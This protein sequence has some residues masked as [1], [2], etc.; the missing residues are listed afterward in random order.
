[1]RE[2]PRDTK[3]SGSRWLRYLEA[4]AL[5]I[6]LIGV[7]VFFSVYPKTANT[8]PTLANL[9]VIFGNQSVLALVALAALIPLVC[10]EWDLSVGASAGLSAV[11]CAKLLSNGT[12]LGM[13]MAA[14]V[15]LGVLVGA[16]NAVL[17]TKVGTNAV[18]TTLGTAAI[19]GGVVTQVTGGTA[20]VSNIPHILT[21]FGSGNTFGVPNTAYV[22]LGVAL[23]VY[24]VLVHTPAGRYI[25]ALGSNREAAA[26]IG[27]RT[28]LILGFTFVA[29]GG[30]AGIAGVLQVARA[31]GAD[32]RIGET[33]TL[34]ALAAAFLSAAAIK[35]GQYNVGG[36]IVA[37]FLLATINSGLAI[38]GAP[39]YLAEYVNGAALIV[40]VALAVNLGRVKR[41]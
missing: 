15:S 36:T 37:L 33:L 22:L 39:P 12:P 16:S 21:R 3:R 13:A 26:L 35:P 10:N 2:T 4:Y 28:K 19:V 32:P 20:Q 27:L 34:P 14:G 8:F 6:L 11:I 23:V 24:Y 30:L 17:I 31:G 40:G 29:A 38:A 1:M 25:Y 41:R 9:Q 7:C 18:I 5:L